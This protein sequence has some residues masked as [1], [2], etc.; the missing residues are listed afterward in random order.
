MFFFTISVLAECLEKN[1]THVHLIEFQSTDHGTIISQSII[2]VLHVLSMLEHNIHAHPI[3]SS[4][5]NERPG[6][7]ECTNQ[8]LSAR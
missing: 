2:Y 1:K 5:I 7:K 8:V 4:H 6:H 3:Y